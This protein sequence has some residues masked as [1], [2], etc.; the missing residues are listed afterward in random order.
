MIVDTTGA[1][2]DQAPP[3]AKELLGLVLPEDGDGSKIVAI[4]LMAR[5]GPGFPGEKLILALREEGLRHGEFGIFHRMADEEDSKPLFSVASLTEPGSFDLTRIKSDAYPGVTLF[6]ILSGVDE[7]IETFD[8][9]LRTGRT[10]SSK[11]DGDLLDEHGNRLSIQRERYL[12]E[13]VIQFQH[14]IPLTQ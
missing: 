3:P 9:M 6:F 8:D 4:R 5:Q 14:R 12:R 11:L 2:T 1:E 7:A 13:E 10:L